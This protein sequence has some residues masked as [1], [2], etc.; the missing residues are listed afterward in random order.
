MRTHRSW[1]STN[2]ISDYLREMISPF[3]Q[4]REV[5]RIG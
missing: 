3:R 4:P 2:R 5:G 1:R